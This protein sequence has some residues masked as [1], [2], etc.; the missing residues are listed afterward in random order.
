MKPIFFIIALLSSGVELS[1][2][3]VRGCPSNKKKFCR[4][5]PFDR[6]IENF[7][8]KLETKI[9]YLGINAVFF[10]T[11]AIFEAAGFDLKTQVRFQ[12]I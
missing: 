6:L 4:G 10:Y 11:N 9:R 8:H 7:Y 2:T 5:S 1:K 3:S 12:E